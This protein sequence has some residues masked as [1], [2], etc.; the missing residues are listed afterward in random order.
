MLRSETFDVPVIC[1]G[2]LAVGGTGKTPHTEYLVRLLQKEFQVAVLSRGYKRRKNGYVLATPESKV[3]DIGD[4]PFQIHTKFPGI[5]VAVDKDRRHGIRQLSK[6]SEPLTDVILLDDGFQ[7]RY[8]D[9]G[10]NILLTDFHRLFCD[11]A[12]LPAGRLREPASEKIRA[13]MVIVT[14]CPPDI[15]PIDFNVIAKRLHLYPYQQLYFSAYR[16]GDLVPVFPEQELPVRPLN[17]LSPDEGILLLTG[18]ASPARMQ[19]ELE[20]YSKNIC[21]LTFA[22]HHAFTRKDIQRLQETF[23]R[24]KEERRIIVT[25][26]KDATRL[27]Q[28]KGMDEE[29]K[30]HLYALPIEVEI[31]QNQQETF[32]QHIL[33]YVRKNKR[34]SI[35]SPK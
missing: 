29:L 8:V 34:N 23:S 22:D 21:L 18:I 19:E 17:S 31:L 20:Q 15:K 1:I 27:L 16:Y 9:A 11:D 24:M 26:E 10:I 5:R 14:K 30:N 28:C 2:N 35:L 33:G 6:L 4:E 7:H 12:L 13:Q 3:E 25:T 32:N